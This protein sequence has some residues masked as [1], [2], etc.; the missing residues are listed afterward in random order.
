MK[1]MIKICGVTRPEDAAHAIEHGADA[2]GLNFWRGSRRFVE[3]Q[4]AREIIAA[5]PPTATKVGVFVNAHPLVVSETLK[6]LCLD[7]VQLHGDEKPS[8]WSDLSPSQLIRVI[9]VSDEASMKHALA[10]KPALFIYDSDTSGVGGSGTKAPWDV[11]AAHA[12]RPFLLAGGLTADNVAEGIHAT[13]PNGVDVASGVES[14]PGIKDPAQVERFIHAAR[15][16]AQALG[17][18]K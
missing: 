14:S 12:R 3:D 17:N 1:F 11:I 2:I 4:Q 18:P 7:G 6:D 13:R 16:A 9:R 10:W 8:A 15:E 5:I